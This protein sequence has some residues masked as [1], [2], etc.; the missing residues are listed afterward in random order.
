MQ[1]RFS[2]LMQA[3]IDYSILDQ[4]VIDMLELIT[5]LKLRYTVKLGAVKQLQF[6]DN[7]GRYTTVH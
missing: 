5:E 4:V 3:V 7:I 2:V 1:K 6:D